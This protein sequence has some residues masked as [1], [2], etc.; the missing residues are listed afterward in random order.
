MNPDARWD[1]SM[2]WTWTPSATWHP[3]LALDAEPSR[4]SK[5][6]HRHKWRQYPPKRDALEDR[7]RAEDYPRGQE[8]Q[9]YK[10][11]RL[12]D[13]QWYSPDEYQP[14]QYYDK[15]QGLEGRSSSFFFI[16]EFM[17]E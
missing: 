10:K 6:W 17:V 3:P 5:D 9:A 1:P 12:N 14:R 13:Q 11:P 7:R 8:G 16:A 4:V 15:N 2:I